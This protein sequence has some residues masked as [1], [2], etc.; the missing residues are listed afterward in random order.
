VSTLGNIA[1]KAISVHL[2]GRLF[3][4]LAEANRAM[5]QF[6]KRSKTSVI[7]VRE[8]LYRSHRNLELDRASRGP[9]A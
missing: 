4:Y 2:G 7:I 6:H 5:Q 9:Y 3:G 8:I 1:E